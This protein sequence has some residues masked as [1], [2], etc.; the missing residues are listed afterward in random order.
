MAEGERTALSSSFLCSPIPKDPSQ[1]FFVDK[2]SSAQVRVALARVGDGVH[3][4]SSG[5][6]RVKKKSG[7]LMDSHVVQSKG[8]SS[9][10]F[11]D[12][13][14][15]PSKSSSA[16]SPERASPLQAREHELRNEGAAA[17]DGLKAELSQQ[18]D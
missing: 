6:F 16:A 5:L 3:G 14:K 12:D 18:Q 7:A 4:R 17:R 13:A 10:S 2:S 8:A 9:D 15:T 11:M 1:V